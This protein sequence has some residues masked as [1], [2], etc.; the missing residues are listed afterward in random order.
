[1]DYG[2]S[3]L[4]RDLVA[5]GHITDSRLTAVGNDPFKWQSVFRD[6]A[7]DQTVTADDGA[8]YPRA[9]LAMH[10]GGKDSMAAKYI[11]WKTEIRDLYGWAL[12]H[13]GEVSATDRKARIKAIVNAYDMG[14]GLDSWVAMHGRGRKVNSVKGTFIHLPEGSGTFSLEGLH[15]ELKASAEWMAKRSR[16]MVAVSYT[17]L[18]L[19]TICSV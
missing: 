5:A 11:K 19:P 15:R 4:G 13:P 8:A 14:Q 2:R 17:H 6:A 12:F 1:M 9:R 7:L 16:S 10:Q 3:P 18:T